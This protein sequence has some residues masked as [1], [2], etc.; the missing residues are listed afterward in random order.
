MGGGIVN[1]SVVVVR[2][3][4]FEQVL[5]GAKLGIVGIVDKS[6]KEPTDLLE[7]LSMEFMVLCLR[8][9]TIQNTSLG[10]IMV[11]VASKFVKG[12]VLE[13]MRNIH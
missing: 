13:K 2:S 6:R 9:V 1:V 11:G 7:L 5:S 12:G 8:V 4:L 10:L 3:A